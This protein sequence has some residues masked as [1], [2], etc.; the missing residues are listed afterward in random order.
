MCEHAAGAQLSTA[1][2]SGAAASQ[3]ANQPA[4]GAVGSG[5]GGASPLGRYIAEL[6]SIRDALV[7]ASEEHQALQKK[8]QEVRSLRS[9]PRCCWST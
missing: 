5:A 2:T 8:L 7:K 9:K 1:G 4:K 3:D 6:S